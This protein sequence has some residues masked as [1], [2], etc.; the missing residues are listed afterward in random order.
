MKSLIKKYPKTCCEKPRDERQE[1][2]KR[3]A[4]AQC[5]A[6]VSKAVAGCHD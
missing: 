2:P 5:C 6:K 1:P 4:V 3:K